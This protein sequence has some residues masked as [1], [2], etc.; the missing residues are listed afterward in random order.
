MSVADV[1]EWPA[2]TAVLFVPGEADINGD[3]S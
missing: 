3:Q 2:S 1:A